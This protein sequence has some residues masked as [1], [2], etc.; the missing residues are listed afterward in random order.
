MLMQANSDK[1]NRNLRVQ[2]NKLRNKVT[3]TIKQT[4]VSYFRNKIEKIKIILSNFGS[5]LNQLDIG[6]K[7]KKNLVLY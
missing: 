3:K 4:K 7:V 5:N 2:Y 6:T 1:T